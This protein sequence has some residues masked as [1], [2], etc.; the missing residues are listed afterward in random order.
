MVSDYTPGDRVP[1]VRSPAEAK[2]LF[3][4]SVTRPPLRPTQP[5]IQ[6]VPGSYPG[7]KG[8]P[9]R[10]ADHSSPYRAEIKNE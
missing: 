8:R 10:D 2:D 7:D 4:A 6:W 9:E 5:P 3:L 1:G